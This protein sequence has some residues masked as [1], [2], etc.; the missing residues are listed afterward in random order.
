MIMKHLMGNYK[1]MRGVSMGGHESSTV[2]DVTMLIMIIYHNDHAR[3][4]HT[5]HS[6]E[7]STASH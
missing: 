4:A 7:G 2:I 3:S 6:Q 5:S 1:S